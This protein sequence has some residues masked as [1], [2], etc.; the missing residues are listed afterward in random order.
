MV[1][2]ADCSTIL[3]S[4]IVRSHQLTVSAQFEARVPAR[5]FR[6]YVCIGR[7]GRELEKKPSE[8]VHAEDVVWSD[9]KVATEAA[10]AVA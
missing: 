4:T 3:D 5:K 8:V 9:G 6:Q 10:N 1:S 7:A 2:A